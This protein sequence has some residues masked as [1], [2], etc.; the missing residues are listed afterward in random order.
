MQDNKII[1]NGHQFISIYQGSSELLPKYNFEEILLQLLSDNY[2]KEVVIKINSIENTCF[3]LTAEKIKKIETDLREIPTSQREVER[4][5]QVEYWL[6][7]GLGCCALAHDEFAGVFRDGLFLH[8]EKRYRLM[9]WCIMPNHVHALIEC[10]YSLPRIVQSWKSYSGRWAILHND[11]LGLGF[12]GGQVWM[13]SYWDRYIRDEAH[14][15]AAVKY[16]HDNPVK[17]GLAETA[18][19]WRW[20]SAFDR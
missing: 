13:R 16:I 20:S 10:R 14:L 11:R 1:K 3:G 7:Q 18:E 9:A 19:S 5:R 4:R 6:D 2:S 15:Q 17:A 8:D 12:L